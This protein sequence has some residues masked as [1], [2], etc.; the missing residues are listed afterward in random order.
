[1]ATAGAKIKNRKGAR[2]LARGG[3]EARKIHIS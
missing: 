3:V 2:I 1:M